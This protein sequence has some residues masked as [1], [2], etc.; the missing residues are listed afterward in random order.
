MKKK[1]VRHKGGGGGGGGGGGRQADRQAEDQICQEK[2]KTELSFTW[3]GQ[4]FLLHFHIMPMDPYLPLPQ[5][6]TM[7][8]IG[9]GYYQ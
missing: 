6:H 5:E 1:V 3:T 4:R 9:S 7:L 2:T 8:R